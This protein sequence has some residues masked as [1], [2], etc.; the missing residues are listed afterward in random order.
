MFPN[1]FSMVGEDFKLQLNE[2]MKRGE[3]RR[4]TSRGVS[5]AFTGVR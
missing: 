4:K 5:W 3:V 2:G 1:S